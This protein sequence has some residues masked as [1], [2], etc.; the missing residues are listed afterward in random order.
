[1]LSR[2]SLLATLSRD[3]CPL[4]DTRTLKRALCLLLVIHLSSLVTG[5]RRRILLTPLIPSSPERF[6]LKKG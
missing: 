1:M 3:R 6:H 5:L 2:P 4:P